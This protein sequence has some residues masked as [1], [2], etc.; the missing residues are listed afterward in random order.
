MVTLEPR[1]GADAVIPITRACDSSSSKFENGIQG[2]DG[3]AGFRVLRSGLRR[4]FPFW[5][6]GGY[7]SQFRF[8]TV[9]PVTAF[10]HVARCNGLSRPGSAAWRTA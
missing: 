6:F 5:E 9:L 10:I 1:S 4:A 3:F 8:V 7:F 2:E